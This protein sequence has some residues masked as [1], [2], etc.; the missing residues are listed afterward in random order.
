MTCSDLRVVHP[1]IVTAFFSVVSASEFWRFSFFLQIAYPAFHSSTHQNS[2]N[3]RSIVGYNCIRSAQA[4]QSASLFHHKTRPQPCQYPHTRHCHVRTTFN[5]QKVRERPNQEPDPSNVLFSVP[6]DVQD[7]EIYISS[8]G[9]CDLL[10]LCYFS[11]H[12]AL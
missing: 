7:D 1:G 6:Q 11:Q 12:T 2:H 3:M 9:Y 4:S 5:Q 8:R 10:P